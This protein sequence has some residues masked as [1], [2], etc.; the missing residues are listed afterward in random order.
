VSS[1]LNQHSQNNFQPAE[2]AAPLRPDPSVAKSTSSPVLNANAWAG[3]SAA[4]DFFQNACFL[5]VDDEPMNVDLLKQHIQRWGCSNVFATTDSRQTMSLFAECQPDI[6]LLDLMMPH[7]DGFQVLQEMQAIIPSHSFLPIL[8]LTADITPE[9]RRRALGA[10]AKDFLTKPLD[11]TELLLRVRNLLQARFLHL[12]LQNQNEL[13]EAKVATRTQHLEEARIALACAQVEILD[14]LGRAG[15]YRDDD[16]GQHTQRVGHI[17]ALIAQQ[18]QLPDAWIDLIRSAAPLHDVGKI[19]VPDEI[20][21]KKGRLSAEEFATMKKH[22][23]IGAAMLGGGQSDLVQMAE[24]IALS[25]HER[26]DGSGYP[27]GLAGEAIPLEGRI[28]SLADVFDALTHHRP[29]KEPWPIEE[30]IQEITRSSGKQF[31]PR[32]VEAFLKLPH[33]ELL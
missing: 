7:L 9:A 17:A 14:R 26:W 33:N 10:G 27:Q 31:D 18:L 30:A 5:V 19:G 22:V 21:L 25:H 12:Q 4:K 20:L 32:I 11:A 16:T 23:S 28:S 24:S 29:Y 13:L 6:I 1:Y 8:V 2:P 3:D 15:E